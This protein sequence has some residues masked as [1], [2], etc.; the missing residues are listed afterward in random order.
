MHPKVCSPNSS[1]VFCKTWLLEW[2]CSSLLECK[3]WAWTSVL[4][5]QNEK[6]TTT[7]EM[8]RSASPTT[9]TGSLDSP[10]EE[11][12][13]TWR[14]SSGLT[15]TPWHMC[16]T[17]TYTT[18]TYI[19]THL[20]IYLRTHTRTQKSKQRIPYISHFLLHSLHILV[21]PIWWKTLTDYY[22]KATLE[23]SS[24][25]GQSNFI[26]EGTWSN[27]A[28]GRHLADQLDW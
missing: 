2:V 9:W 16:P 23:P 17:I 1:R 3:A 10:V 25:F 21:S 13:D 4:E 8:G 22:R 20:H 24:C 6:P 14:L 5:K 11:R 15:C 7:R 12:T 26:S 28:G 18:H 19:H 27:Y